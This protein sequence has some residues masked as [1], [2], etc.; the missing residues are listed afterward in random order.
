MRTMTTK[1]WD[2]TGAGAAALRIAAV[3]AAAMAMAGCVATALKMGEAKGTVTGAAGGASAEGQ[4]T[5]LARC[6]APLGTLALV[7]DQAA[8]WWAELRQ[9]NLGS[10][11][12]VLR[13]MVQQSNCFVVVERDGLVL[14]H[15]ELVRVRRGMERDTGRLP[16]YYLPDELV[17]RCRSL[18]AESL[19]G[20]D[21]V[22]SP[23]DRNY[24]DPV[25]GSY[26][27]RWLAAFAPVLVG[28]Q[29]TGWVV[30]AQ[31]RLGFD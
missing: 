31:E 15:A 27:G 19:R 29:D 16:S 4:N 8:P 7:E 25:G 11:I 6:D 2:L 5:Q 3:A 17:T 21:P 24:R 30:I 22:T 12:P 14:Q 28:D 26:G 10:T 20:A 9:R 13:L 1:T 18:A 23:L